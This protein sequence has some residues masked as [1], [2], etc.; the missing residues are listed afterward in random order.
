MRGSRGGQ[1]V[2]IPLKDHKNIGFLSNTGP[3]PLNNHNATKSAFNVGPLLACQQNAIYMPFRW[4]AD[5]G[6]LLVVF[7]SPHQLKNVVKIDTPSPEK[8][9]WIRAC[10]L[11]DIDDKQHGHLADESCQSFYR[12]SQQPIKFKDNCYRNYSRRLLCGVG[13]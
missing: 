13:R 3:D 2:W 1:G 7:G 8:T 4:R 6:P 12:Y 11:S 9:F 5:D 10:H